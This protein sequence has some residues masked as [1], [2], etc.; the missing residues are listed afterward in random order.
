VIELP[1]EA[2][3]RCSAE[4]I[5]DLIVDFDG[6]SRWLARSSAFH[7]T[8]DISADQ[9]TLGT[10]YREPSP[11]GVRHGTVTEFDRP[12]RVTFH[13]PM[14]L[15]LH[16]GTIEVTLRYVLTPHGDFT[17][18]RRAVTIGIPWS[19]KLLQPMIVQ[20]FRAESA[21]TLEALKAY[22]DTVS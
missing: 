2:E 18:V 12:T 22:A 5:F 17:H 20:S 3:I 16:T 15:R 14:T 6:Q 13:Q 8:A 21:R 10:T 7:G 9:V 19:L 1:S 4:R 11:L